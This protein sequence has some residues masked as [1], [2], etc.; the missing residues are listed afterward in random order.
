MALRYLAV[1][2]LLLVAWTGAAG[3]QEDKAVFRPIPSST[4][5]LMNSQRTHVL[6]LLHK[7]FPGSKLTGTSA[8]FATLQR[9]VD[10]KVISKASTWEWHCL[11][12]AFGD[13]LAKTIPGLQWQEVTDAYGTDPV[14]RYESTSM[15]L[16]AMTML[17]KRVEEG[18]EIDLQ[19]LAAQL[20]KFVRE[21]AHEFR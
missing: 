21:K 20:Q 6:R 17:S 16:S 14:L 11:G 12:I 19:D 4:L 10:A 8:D 1:L 18:R 5:L 7:H 9:I 3:A 13:V 15:R 2:A